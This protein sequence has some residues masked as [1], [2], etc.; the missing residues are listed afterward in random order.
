VVLV[1]SLLLA[2]P[3]LAATWTEIEGT[4]NA[5]HIRGTDAS[6]R[7]YG[8][9]GD[10][11]LRGRA[12]DDRLVGGPGNDVL[13]GGSGQDAHICGAGRD[14]VVIQPPR[15]A[16]RIGDGCEVL[17]LDVP[18]HRPPARGSVGPERPF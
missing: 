9:D 15:A 7:I 6:D 13:A 14:V 16:E 5:D 12:G 10:D 18:P 11:V 2:A 8:L 4:A 1:A 3:A 17:I